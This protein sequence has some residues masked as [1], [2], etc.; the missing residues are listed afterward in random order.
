LPGSHVRH[1]EISKSSGSIIK[2]FPFFED[3]FF[4][5]FFF[6]VHQSVDIWAAHGLFGKLSKLK[7]RHAKYFFCAC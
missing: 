2:I 3:A 5:D 7:N 6:M 4:C 1:R